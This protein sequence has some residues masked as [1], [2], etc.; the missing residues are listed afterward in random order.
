MTGDHALLDLNRF[1]GVIPKQ[2]TVRTK[3][4]DSLSSDSI[5]IVIPAQVL[6]GRRHKVN[7]VHQSDVMI[8]TSFIILKIINTKLWV[9]LCANAYMS[10]SLR[11]SHPS[12]CLCTCVLPALNVYPMMIMMMMMICP[13]DGTDSNPKQPTAAR[14]SSSINGR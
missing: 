3:S 9:Y 7:H 4:R 14:C 2:V 6:K 12:M 11:D 13:E 5:P 8:L 1:Q 10:P